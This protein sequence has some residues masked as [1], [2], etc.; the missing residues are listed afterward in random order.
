MSLLATAQNAIE[1]LLPRP[2]RGQ[3]MPGTTRLIRD[4]YHFLASLFGEATA[5]LQAT[6]G[7][8]R[9]AWGYRLYPRRMSCY[10]LPG[11]PRS[12]ALAE[13]RAKNPGW[14]FRADYDP[15]EWVVIFLHG[16]VDNSGADLS[17]RRLASLGYTVYAVRVPFLR[18]VPELARA[19]LGQLR[20]IRR[21]EGERRYV[22]IG[23][24]LGGFVWDHLLL[25]C[26][27]LAKRYAMPL[28]I[29]I[30]SP[31]LGTF[32]AHLAPGGSGRDMRPG[33]RIV[34]QH[35]ARRYPPGLEVYNFISRFDMVVFPIET[36]LWPE[37]IN[38]IFSETGHIGQLVRPHVELAIEEVFASHPDDLHARCEWRRFTPTAFTAAA[39]QLPEAVQGVLGLRDMV[40]F[41]HGD[42]NLCPRFRIRV[43]HRELRDGRFP[44]LE[45]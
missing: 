24:S 16:Y 7:Y 30:G 17:I 25:T 18:S 37:G 40:R 8:L 14:R 34:Q 27:D 3:P 13:L 44:R 15:E 31:R 21:R 28:Y 4:G 45:R 39:S 29:P 23:H 42:E 11:A 20:R 43:V 2:A 33:S 26:P 6:P 9:E 35:L 41:V 5:I 38:Y 1:S 36:S 12:G 10:R 22:P 32:I 19:L